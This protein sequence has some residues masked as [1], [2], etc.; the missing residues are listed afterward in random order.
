M[1]APSPP[2]IPHR[3]SID[4]P[5]GRAPAS[6]SP[7]FLSTAAAQPPGSVQQSAT[8]YDLEGRRVSFDGSRTATGQYPAGGSRPSPSPPP[9][10]P[11]RNSSSGI[12]TR[13]L[14]KKNRTN[15][16]ASSASSQS[17]SLASPL[18]SPKLPSNP[19]SP[20]SSPGAFSHSSPYPFTPSMRPV[21]PSPY[22]SYQSSP[23]PPS[24]AAPPPGHRLGSM[25]SSHP[26]AT[27][28]RIPETEEEQLARIQQESLEY[29]QQR[30]MD[31]EDEEDRRLQQALAESAALAEQEQIRADERERIRRKEEEIAVREAL[32]YSREFEQ[33]EAE[34]IAREE[35]RRSLE[36]EKEVQR[37]LARSRTVDRRRNDPEHDNGERVISEAVSRLHLDDDPGARWEGGNLE[38]PN[39]RDAENHS[40]RQSDATT[41]EWTSEAIPTSPAQSSFV[42]ANPD[43]SLSN[44]DGSDDD[45]DGPPPSYSLM[46]EEPQRPG[47]SA[48]TRLLGPR[49]SSTPS[50]PPR[51]PPG[52]APS[53][54]SLHESSASRSRTVSPPSSGFFSSA[55]ST[56]ATVGPYE[57][58]NS[59]SPTLFDSIAVQD[60]V[61]DEHELAGSPGNPFDDQFAATYDEEDEEGDNDDNGTPEGA[62]QR[63]RW[64]TSQSGPAEQIES[65]QPAIVIEAAPSPSPTSST[66]PPTYSHPPPPLPLDSLGVHSS[67]PAP[68]RRV[69]EPP[70][71]VP[72]LL[73]S[74]GL[75]FTSSHSA[76]NT[77]EPSPGLD[78]Y[79]ESPSYGGIVEDHGPSTLATAQYVLQGVSWGF[80]SVERAAMHPPLDSK[81]AFPR[82]AQLSSSKTEEGK[83]TFMSFAIEAKS[84]NSLLVYLTWFGKSRF[85][86]SPHDHG[87]DET[88]QGHQ[89]S[90]RIEFFRS[91]L[92][93]SCRVRCRLELLPLLQSRPLSSETTSPNASTA[94][95]APSFDNDCP[96]VHI[97]LSHRPHLPLTLSNLASV[98]VNA[99]AHSRTHQQQASKHSSSSSA[100]GQ[101]Q[102]CLSEA[103]E[104]LRR[105]N[106][107]TRDEDCDD[108]NDSDDVG[109]TNKIKSRLRKRKVRV[110]RTETQQSADRRSVLPEGAMM[111]SPFSIE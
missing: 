96:T 90:I 29:E 20:L 49:D 73:P 28:T 9:I 111:I 19:H 87:A 12:F 17:P 16:S 91:F 64:D 43:R 1:T 30:L 83:Q 38:E 48:S 104:L 39:L 3:H 102:G 67:S 22:P 11:S 77:P 50:L 24:G 74:P 32:V 97:L 95:T 40:R 70:P 46:A 65:L 14:L 84:W 106:G 6:P 107:E 15:S 59:A 101:R 34:R 8:R 81:G 69:S 71:S 57:P 2:Y 13:K 10:A 53:Q 89:V 66:V 110:I 4:S 98:L 109:W 99:L 23:L 44:I 61:A 76:N 60:S 100:L 26:P 45:E 85:E 105:L 72:T 37:V 7:P 63:E 33:A 41:N 42:V 94:E 31:L 75:P 103:V 18:P 21:Y 5:Y 82:G 88:G 80:V 25:T 56:V 51:P 58:V 54:V 62:R 108:G 68:I 36:E 79:P 78:T 86:A 47:T 55:A 93:S 35:R 27:P 52:A 92:D